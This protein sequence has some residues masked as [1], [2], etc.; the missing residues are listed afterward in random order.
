MA[1]TDVSEQTGTALRRLRE[2]LVGTRVIVRLWTDA[3]AQSLFSAI[4]TA[5][6]HLSPWMDWVDRHQTVADTRDYITRTLLEFTRRESLSLGIFDRSNEQRVLGSSGYHNI[7]WAVP[8]LEIGYWIIP[9]AEGQGYVTEAVGL[10]TDFALEEF[11][12]NRIAIHCDPRNERS[13]RVAER[14]G[15][16]FEGRLRNKTRTP[17]GDLRDSLVFSLVPE[18]RRAGP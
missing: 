10:L 18:D 13:R 5:R 1:E 4:D 17:A 15:Y 14:L 11:G 6:H 3:D 7:D 16:Q 2:G 9:D 12:T 8:A